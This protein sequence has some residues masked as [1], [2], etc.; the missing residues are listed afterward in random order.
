MPTQ[1]E[2]NLIWRR[3]RAQMGLATKGEWA[4]S[5]LGDLHLLRHV[6]SPYPTWQRAAPKGPWIL[7]EPSQEK[8]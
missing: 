5:D 2:L 7:Q 6:K 8:V 3:A 1:L 4:A